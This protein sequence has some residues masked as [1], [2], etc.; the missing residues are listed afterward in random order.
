M[1][2]DTSLVLRW[3]LSHW[4]R[5]QC[6]CIVV[7]AW[8]NTQTIRPFGRRANPCADTEGSNPDLTAEVWEIWPCTINPAGVLVF[9]N[10]KEKITTV[11]Q[12]SWGTWSKDFRAHRPS[13]HL[14]PRWR[15]LGH[16]SLIRQTYVSSTVY[17]LYSET[18]SGC[19]VLH[20]QPSWLREAVKFSL[21]LQWRLHIWFADY[22]SPSFSALANKHRCFSCWT[23]RQNTNTK[24]SFGFDKLISLPPHR[25]VPAVKQYD[26]LRNSEIKAV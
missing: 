4:H 15:G 5:V 25:A 3:F 23:S 22:F 7:S 6:G 10:P 11:K 12:K 1:V 16:Q 26:I 21:Y 17:L 24:I 14:Q 9:T 13:H 2:A 8:T 18:R 20:T 19:S